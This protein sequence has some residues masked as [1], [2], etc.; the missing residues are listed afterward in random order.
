MFQKL[1]SLRTKLS[2][3]LLLASATATFI[4]SVLLVSCWAYFSIQSLQEDLEATADALGRNC[5]AAILFDTP[6]D[7]EKILETLKSKPSIST[8]RIF[9]GEGDTFATYPKS[10][11]IDDF[12]VA[13]F[14][15]YP[16]HR[17]TWSEAELFSDIIFDGER[18]GVFYLKDDLSG[19]WKSLYPL[20]LT[21]PFVQILALLL[22]YALLLR[23][24]RQITKPIL[25]LSDVANTI[26]RENDYSV[27]ALKE[28]PDEIG[29]L[30]DAFNLMLDE[31]E[32]RNQDLQAGEERY[33]GLLSSI[34]LPII[35]MDQG[36]FLYL[37]P[38]A[39]RLLDSDEPEA[40]IGKSIRAYL[41]PIEED[42]TKWLLSKQA[43]EGGTPIY[44]ML[45]FH[46]SDQKVIDIDMT[47]INMN[48][49][50][51]SARL[52][53]CVD[54]T[55]KLQVA[56]QLEVHRNRLEEMVEERTE[57]LKNAQEKLLVQERLAVLGQ[58]TATVSHEL[59]NPM[60]T[61]SNSIYNLKMALDAGVMEVAQQSISI[62]ERNIVRCDRIINELLDFSRKG[63]ADLHPAS[64]SD[65]LTQVLDELSCPTDIALSREFLVDAVVDYDSE[66]LRRAIINLIINAQQA[67]QDVS[68]DKKII[69]STRIN[70]D[71]FEI[72]I[73]DN[74]PG[75]PETLQEKIFEPL[76]STKNFGVGLGMTIVKDIMENHL[77]GIELLPRIHGQG[78]RFV[79]WLP[80]ADVN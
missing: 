59:R 78:C 1:T 8:A 70:N 15:N 63:S 32:S 26:S 79:L 39:A 64:M 66:N 34:T 29:Q 74:G 11:A 37:N 67:L 18:V 12:S 48:F 65:F 75:I 27:R 3:L 47:A 49:D 46:L 7:A 56:K 80:L 4:A 35:V 68:H 72:H 5:V 31:V 9:I 71:K 50:G 24:L 30:T 6:N 42:A 55:E 38:A 23:V 77:G 41:C 52:V 54:V 25:G 20:F 19:I 28:S 53:I 58:L 36:E 51:K 2:F 17:L 44:M 14:E 60:G 21:V 61:I 40:L 16:V 73:E 45:Q 10:L 57:E 76:F 69:V 62:A 43:C 22:T 13:A 33:R